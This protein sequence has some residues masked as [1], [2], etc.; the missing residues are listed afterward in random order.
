VFY[1][2][3]EVIDVPILDLASDPGRE[4][5]ERLLSVVEI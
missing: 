5:W 4:I 1:S 3:P 2:H